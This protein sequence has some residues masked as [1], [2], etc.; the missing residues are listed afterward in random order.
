[1]IL[2]I[3]R[4]VRNPLFHPFLFQQNLKSIL[5][6]LYRGIMYGNGSILLPAPSL[7]RNYEALSHWFLHTSWGI[8]ST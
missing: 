6:Y 1:M 2:S 7:S 4:N 5:P 8:L 3:G